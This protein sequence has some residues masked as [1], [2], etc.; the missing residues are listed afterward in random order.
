ML[1]ILT[2]PSLHTVRGDTFTREHTGLIS[3]STAEL[4]LQRQRGVPS[5]ELSQTLSDQGLQRN[6][7]GGWLYLQ[8]SKP[9]SD[10]SHCSHSTRS[11]LT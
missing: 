5:C 3:S 9:I 6:T 1:I 11:F 10:L 8:P 2:E 7:E 4:R